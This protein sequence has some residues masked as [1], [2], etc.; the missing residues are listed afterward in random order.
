MSALDNLPPDQRAVLQMVL[1][2]GRSYDEIA[3][4]LSIDRA[5]VRQRAL[6]AFDALTPV[7]VLAGPERALVTDYLLGQLPDR[8]AE[9]VYSFL[10]AS[11]ADRAWAEAL[12]AVLG[13]LAPGSLPE[14]PVGAPLGADDGAA[15]GLEPDSDPPDLEGAEEPSVYAA[16][17]A[18]EPEARTRPAREPR[19][20]RQPRSPREPRPASRRGGAILL[21]AL[22]VLIVAVI[23]V[24]IATSGGGAKHHGHS[25]DTGSTTTA[26]QSASTTVTTGT[27]STSTGSSTTAPPLA[28]LNLKSP[29]G[30]KSTVGIVLVVRE[31]GVIGILLA[32]QGLPPN[33]AH[34]AYAVWLYNSP[35]SFKLIGFV[36][37]LVGK[38]GKLDTTAK[39]GAGAA[40]YHHLLITLESKPHPS[41]PG[42]V[43]LS[44]P[45]REHS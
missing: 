11:D 43:V 16:P 21:S 33:T 9:E 2:R 4:L 5:A 8:V 13:P 22:G 27:S 35:S 41:A 12:A 40:S 3:S 32:A 38:S 19:A 28:Q 37:N 30:A 29:T 31:N 23:V 7:T 44:G 42:E 14:I 1:Q 39:L 18:E 15:G 34:N 45:F 24:V 20:A 26:A 25:N 6:D 36:P 17:V 10:Q